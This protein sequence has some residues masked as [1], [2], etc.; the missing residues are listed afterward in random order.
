MIPSSPIKLNNNKVTVELKDASG[1][2]H[3]CGYTTVSL[4]AL[5]PE[6]D[7]MLSAGP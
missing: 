4:D 6:E 1:N 5:S 3:Y 7:E 2:V